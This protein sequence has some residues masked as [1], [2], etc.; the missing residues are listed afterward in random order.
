MSSRATSVFRIPIPRGAYPEREQPRLSWLDEAGDRASGPLLRRL[1]AWRSRGAR[2]VA[3]T[4]EL[5]AAMERRSDLELR[6]EAKELRLPLRREGFTE[7]LV[8]RTFALVREAARRTIGQRHYDVQILGGSVLLRGMIAEMET[9][10]GKT[11]AAT[12]PA[13]TAAMA[14][15]PVHIITVNDYLVTRD[16]HDM[17][18][19]F[20]ALGLSVGAVQHGMGLPERRASYACDV[21]YCSNKELVFDYLKDRLALGPH[22]S[23][24]RL[25]LD[26]LREGRSRADGLLLRGLCFGI[27]DEADSVL[28]DEARTPLIIS[29]PGDRDQLEHEL[30]RTAMSLAEKLAGGTDFLVDPRERRIRLTPQGEARI[31]KLTGPL[32]GVWSGRQ[33]R[34]SFVIQALT[35]LHLFHRDQHYLVADGK[36]RIIDEYTGRVMAD[37]SWERGLHQMI[38][39][40]EG[41]DTTRRVEPLAR[42]SYQRFFR[43][44]VRL[45]GM[46]GTAREVA[47]ELWSVYRLPL[48]RIPTYRPLRRQDVGDRVFRTAA[49][50]WGAVVGRIKEIHER[51]RPILAGTRSVAASEHLSALLRGEGLEHRVLNARQDRE[52]AE[53]IAQAGQGSRITV[54]TNMAGR[55]TD[56]ALSPEALE[57]G[58]LH[59]IATERHEARRIDR[60]LLGRGG[61]QGDPGTYEV[62]TSLEDDLVRAHGSGLRSVEPVSRWVAS[63]A[64]TSALR[65]GIVWQAQRRAER[66]HSKIRRELVKMDER[67][68]T[69]LAFSGRGE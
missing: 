15:I 67:I 49:E 27:V 31:R 10:E 63:A 38:E 40:K 44:Y 59:V 9:G 51:G 24:A 42:I 61:R 21:T 22:R 62:M 46:T 36:V 11:L 14:G 5:S 68:E 23:R 32:G 48:A 20:R 19:V 18:P 28:I 66:L 3:R 64:P 54:A 45:A 55:G 37:R 8:A 4:A 17:G 60:Q 1:R 16:A 26:R 12:L 69:M 43:R 41:C 30:Y 6:Q 29:A 2:I 47:A 65:R 56:I 52:E 50:K 34:E 35:A 53:I 33:R 25:Q 39:V 13:C 57:A 58:G 7:P